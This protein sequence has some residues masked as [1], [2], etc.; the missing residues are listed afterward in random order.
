MISVTS[1]TNDYIIQPSLIEKHRRTLNWLSS[2]VLWQR[3]F[4]F[5]QK[6]LDQSAPKFSR[7]E[8]KKKIDHFQN[9]IIYYNGELIGELRKKLRDHEHRLADMLQTKDERKTEYFKEH[10]AL[11]LELESFSNSFAEY[12]EEFFEFIEGA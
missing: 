12:K 3:E 8:D 5:F 9:L 2:T 11:M 6:I 10:D 1:V 4:N 7:I